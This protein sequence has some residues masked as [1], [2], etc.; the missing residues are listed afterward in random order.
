MNAHALPSDCRMCFPI[1][2][3]CRSIVDIPTLATTNNTTARKP[4]MAVAGFFG[5]AV[6]R[7]CV[8]P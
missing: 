2:L 1:S 3:A 7:S 4:S 5:L 6:V 8:R